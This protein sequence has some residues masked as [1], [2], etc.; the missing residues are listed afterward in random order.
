M[1]ACPTL[2]PQILAALGANVPVLVVA[3]RFTDG[4][5]QTQCGHPLAGDAALAVS[6]LVP[7]FASSSVMPPRVCR[8]R[9]IGKDE[10]NGHCGIR[11]I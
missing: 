10:P 7:R 8:C 4:D 6:A 1:L 5:R 3:T 11:G 9:S 2:L